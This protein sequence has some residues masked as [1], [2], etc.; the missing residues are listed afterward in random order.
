[1]QAKISNEMKEYYFKISCLCRLK[2]ATPIV[3]CLNVGTDTKEDIV[4]DSN[5]INKI[6]A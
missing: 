3:Q 4:T 6:M 1:M 2:K 5:Q